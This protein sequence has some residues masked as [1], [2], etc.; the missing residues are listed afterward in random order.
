MDIQLPASLIQNMEEVIFRQ[1]QKLLASICSWKGWNLSE[2]EN[3]FLKK[4]VNFVSLRFS[5]TTINNSNI[6]SRVRNIWK[7]KGSK[8]LLETISDNV[9][10]LECE[11][12][13]KKY[14]DDIIEAEED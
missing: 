12:I 5:E 7:H 14:G 9:Y 6:E 8:F 3:E 1:N 4:K 10:S 11:F 2:M 13:G